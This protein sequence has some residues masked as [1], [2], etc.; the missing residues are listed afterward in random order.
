MVAAR[1]ASAAAMARTVGRASRVVR[2]V[3]EDNDAFN[4]AVERAIEE[5]ASRRRVCET[6]R[7]EGNWRS[8]AQA[9]LYVA[10]A[11]D[12]S[13]PPQAQPYNRGHNP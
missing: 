8:V 12:A 3:A 13:L 10:V 4:R 2:V 11:Q 9:L 7:A 1:A 6:A 5:A